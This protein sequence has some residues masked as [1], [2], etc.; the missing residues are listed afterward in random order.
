MISVVVPTYNR[1]PLLGMCLN[2][3]MNQTHNDYEII[4]VDD[5]STDGTPSLVKSLQ[6]EFKGLRYFRQ[7]NQG[8]SVARNLGFSRAR[9]EIIASTDDDCVA[10]GE[11]LERIE[12][13]LIKHPNIAA[14]GGSILNPLDTRISRAHHILMYSSFFPE[15]RKGYV[16]DIPTCNIAYRREF[17]K[18]LG[19][20]DDKKALSYRDSLFNL[21][22]SRRGR[23]LFDPEIRVLHYRWLGGGAISEFLKTQ[24]RQGMGFYNGGYVFHG[25]VGRILRGLW[26]INLLCPRLALVFFRC[27]KSGRALEFMERLPMVLRGEMERL[28]RSYEQV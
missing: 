16:R 12:E 11:W 28:R 26:P 24:R 3:L 13:G 6:G 2:S 9:G 5:G 22:V 15:T 14:I 8:H 10:E 17:I 19:F 4:V 20:Q 7:E 18:G 23:I 27:L 1:K 25:I 21:E